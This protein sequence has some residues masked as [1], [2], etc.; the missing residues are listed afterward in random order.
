MTKSK[1][2]L[3]AREYWTADQL[4]QMT[5][6]YPHHRTADIEAQIG[7]PAASIYSKAKILGLKKSAEFLASGQ[8]GRLDGVRGG[9]TRFKPGSTSWNKGSHYIAGGRSAET[10]FKPGH[11]GGRAAEVYVPVGTE[12]VRDGYLTRKINEDMPLHKRWRAV[13]LLDWE[14]VNGPV[15]KGHIVAFRDGDK[16]NRS[17]GNLE[18]VSRVE[19]MLRN[20]VHNL[21][22]EVVEVVRLRAVV[23]R[24]INR[25]QKD[26]NEQRDHC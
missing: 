15:P 20:T 24:K 14:A 21:P 12:R 11:R 16:S 19:W 10:R 13:H 17:M 7:R 22:K 3:P 9:Q 1:N 6:L 25:I 26:A 2:I 18:L 23:V 4:Q 8:A 5:D